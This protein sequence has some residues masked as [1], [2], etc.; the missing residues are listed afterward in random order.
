MFTGLIQSTGKLIAIQDTG[1]DARLRFELDDPGFMKH[2]EMGASIACNG[3]CLTVVAVHPSQENATGF[4]ADA[5]KETLSLTSLGQVAVG[6]IMNFE[7][8]LTL[9]QPLG[10]HLVS[11]HVDGMAKVVSKQKAANAWHYRL[12]APAA[13]AR[14]I[15][16]KG[17]VCLDGISLTVNAVEANDFEIM[18]IPH[19]YKETNIQGWE[20]GTEVNLEVDLIAR[21]L[22]RLFSGSASVAPQSLTY[23]KIAAAGFSAKT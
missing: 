2:A 13:L 11:G 7:K 4:S 9:Q 18:I 22:E 6:G 5:S 17:S 12:S 14:Y 19:T 15:A 20:V 8:S 21:Y 10:G 16:R 1:G 23:E 3:C